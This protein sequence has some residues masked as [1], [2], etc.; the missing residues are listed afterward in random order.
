MQLNNSIYKKPDK[1]PKASM[2]IFSLALNGYELLYK[3]YLDSHRAYAS[4]LQC[5]YVPVVKPHFSSLGVECCWLKIYLL[6]QALNVGYQHV[7]FLDADA[8]VQPHAPDIR[9]ALNSDKSV[10]LARGY[11]GDY[12]SGVILVNNDTEAKLFLQNVIQHRFIDKKESVG[13]GENDSVI[14]VAE[15]ADYIETLSTRWNNTADESLDDYIRHINFGPLRTSKKR[16]IF[17]KCLS[18]LTRALWWGT[19]ILPRERRQNML[20]Q[21]TH[22]TLRRILKHYSQ[23]R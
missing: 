4:R 17:H 16:N 13:W 1:E 9:I 23:F 10:Y 8:F 22:S 7:L 15:N 3:S 21:A 18:R 19:K 2:L 20:I 5:D 12:N 6:Q 11:S 14:A